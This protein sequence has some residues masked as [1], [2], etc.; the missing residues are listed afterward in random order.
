MKKKIL[1]I[2]IILFVIGAVSIY[3][4]ASNNPTIKIGVGGGHGLEIIHVSHSTIFDVPISKEIQAN[5]MEIHE[6][7]DA[8]VSFLMEETME[9]RDIRV[10][11]EAVDGKTIDSKTVLRYVGY[12]TSK[13]GE[14][15]RYLEEKVFDF[16]IVPEEELF[17]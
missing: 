5:L 14:E 11:I 15:I 12:Y 2:A 7:N 3:V 6:W 16:I 10:S 8:V 1:P 13:D 9:P 17:K 4:Y